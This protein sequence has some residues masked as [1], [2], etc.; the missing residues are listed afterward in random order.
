MI[1]RA[2]RGYCV[3]QI[4]RHYALRDLTLPRC[5][6]VPL[7]SIASCLTHKWN[8]H[9]M[10][11]CDLIWNHDVIIGIIIVF[12]IS[13]SSSLLHNHTLIDY[14]VFIYTNILCFALSYWYDIG[15][16]FKLNIHCRWPLCIYNIRLHTAWYSVSSMKHLFH[17]LWKWNA[18]IKRIL[19]AFYILS[20]FSPL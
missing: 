11:D 2:L 9:P 16:R 17:Y 8:N 5:P 19:N 7:I 20:I 1:V 15:M 18:V 4:T 6:F 3:R 12:V 13:Q 10:T 14:I